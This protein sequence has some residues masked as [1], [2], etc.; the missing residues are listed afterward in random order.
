MLGGNYHETKNMILALE[1]I[2]KA[3]LVHDD[4]VDKADL[5]SQNGVKKSILTGD[6]LLSMG[7]MHAAKTGKPEVVRW[8]AETALKIVQGMN[9]HD[10]HK[11]IS[12]DEYLH[13]T[14]LK[15]GSLF[16]AAA[17]FG[18]L[19]GSGK[20]ED[21]EKL[22]EFG[23]FF[24]NA[25]QIR[26]DIIA[27]FSIMGNEKSLEYD[28]LNGGSSLLL[29]YAID[30]E[31][32]TQEDKEG[33]LSIANKEKNLDV[34]FVQRVYEYTGALQKSIDKMKEFVSLSEMILNGYPDSDAKD[35]LQE[36]LDQFNHDFSGTPEYYLDSS[37]MRP[38]KL[39]LDQ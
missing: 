29:V 14:H 2:N 17:A 25:Y 20:A 8:L 36:L 9:W 30:S 35:S 1:L 7:L 6:T 10:Q 11:L 33:L 22:S 32:I 28:P 16:E 18:G 39:E 4:I 13:V 37:D 24:G 19:A 26:D 23:K 38:L 21:V 34:N 27:Y 31:K 12:V 3:T 5:R 15:S